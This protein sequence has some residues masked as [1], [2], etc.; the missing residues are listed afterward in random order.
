MDSNVVRIFDTTLRDGEQAPGFSLTSEQKLAMARQLQQLRV[1]VIEAGFPA[2]S[3]DDFTAVQRIAR[4]IEGPIIAGLAR[5]V[6]DDVDACARAVKDAARPRIHTFISTSDIHLEGQFR[7]SR[8]QATERAVEMVSRAKSYVDD[9]EFSPMDATRSEWEYVYEVLEAVI[10]AGATTVNIAD[11]CGYAQPEEFGRFIRSIRENVRG[12]ERAVISVHC[13]NDLG[14]ATANSLIAI[15]NGARQVECCING[16]GERAGNA[17]LEEVV[18]ALK[19]RKD[20]YGVDVNVDT[21]QLVPASRMLSAFTNSPVQRNKAVVGDN[22][23]AHESGIHQDGMLKDTRTYEIME[24]AMVGYG[25]TK[26]VLGKHSG[27]H[28]L[29][30]RLAQLGHTLTQEE[31][32]ETFVRFKE[33]ADRKKEITDEDLEEILVR[34]H[35]GAMRAISHVYR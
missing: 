2:A 12:I 19:I 17:A 31:L 16:I 29:K 1:D 3:P 34:T 24:A 6:A 32:N 15:Q 18:M 26:L 7:L 23:F 4:E 22:A 14:L 5:C 30:V 13:H 9:V 27:R 20:I 28:A 33:L 10:A 8:Q 21:S 11:T 25:S 35:A